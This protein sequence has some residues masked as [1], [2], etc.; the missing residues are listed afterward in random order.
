MTNAS[1]NTLTI[2]TNASVAYATG[3]VI[4]VIMGGA[5]TTSITGDTG[6]TVNG[7]SAGSGDIS[8]QYQGVALI[9]TGT[10]TWIASG[11]IGTVA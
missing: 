5:G 3:T 1:A 10:D 8:A 11:A 2:P 4:N 7:I 9:K 6:V